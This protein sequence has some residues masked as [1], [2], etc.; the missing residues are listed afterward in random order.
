MG[1]FAD[2]LEAIALHPPDHRKLITIIDTSEAQ[3]IIS[4]ASTSANLHKRIL[5]Y[6]PKLS[7]KLEGLA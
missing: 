2:R 6:C 3:A 7:E 4:A 5:K 1:V